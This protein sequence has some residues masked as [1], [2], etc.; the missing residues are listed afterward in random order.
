M[1]KNFC[2]DRPNLSRAERGQV[3]DL[4][5]VRRKREVCTGPGTSV[6]WH[7]WAHN[8]ILITLTALEQLV[9]GIGWSLMTWPGNKVFPGRYNVTR[10]VINQ[11]FLET[12]G[13]LALERYLNPAAQGPYWTQTG[14]SGFCATTWVLRIAQSTET[15][16]S[17]SSCCLN[18]LLYQP[19]LRA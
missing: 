12:V 4:A 5:T 11:D 18:L 2:L 10:A 15:G 17:H 1:G 14:R 9:T 16:N 6:P 13:H 3:G 8:N 7:L 19:V